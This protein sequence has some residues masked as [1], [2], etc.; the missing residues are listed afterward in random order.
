MFETGNN[1]IR[2]RFDWTLPN[3]SVGHN[4]THWRLFLP[5]AGAPST[6]AQAAIENFRDARLPNLMTILGDDIALDSL[7]VYVSDPVART[8]VEQF[9]VPV[10]LLG[11]IVGR[12]MPSVIS[13]LIGLRTANNRVSGRV[14]LPGIDF[15]H[16][17]FNGLLSSTGLTDVST[18][19]GNVYRPYTDVLLRMLTPTVFS[20]LPW[21]FSEV[22]A[23]SVSNVLSHQIRRKFGV[24]V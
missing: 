2:L 8:F 19:A 9:T 23:V 17:G 5:S 24:G 10:N 22:T 15:S 13:G 6:I 14:H 21:T 16:V 20:R 11:S 12:A 18:V 3:G 1:N 4:V 7:T